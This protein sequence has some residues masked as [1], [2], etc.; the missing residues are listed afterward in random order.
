MFNLCFRMSKLY[1]YTEMCI[2]TIPH[3]N[4]A[5]YTIFRT[6]SILTKPLIFFFKVAMVSSLSLI[7]ASSFAF[8]FVKSLTLCSQKILKS[9]NVDGQYAE[10]LDQYS[11]DHEIGP[12][13]VIS[14][15]ELNKFLYFLTQ[16]LFSLNEKKNKE[17]K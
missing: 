3:C 11:L 1:M 10:K 5:T 12:L 15:L 9:N 6:I 4:L 7:W 13:V 16:L 8:A 2:E 14:V 17:I